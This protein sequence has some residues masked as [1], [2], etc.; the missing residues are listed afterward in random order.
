[1]A[2][3][4]NE[5]GVSKGTP[6]LYFAAKETLYI[7]LHDQWDCALGA[8]VDTA[9]RERPAAHE[10]SPRERKDVEL[11]LGQGML[12]VGRHAHTL[13]APGKFLLSAPE[14]DTPPR[15]RCYLLTDEAV[16]VAPR[17]HR[18]RLTG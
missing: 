12:A 10:R 2:D 18:C 5:T 11:T 13:N 9:T 17:L 6:Y 8:R 4:A 3:I 16:A 15:A 14:H 1:M 7:A